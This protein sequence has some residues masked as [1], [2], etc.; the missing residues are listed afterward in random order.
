MRPSLQSIELSVDGYKI[1]G[2]RQCDDNLSNPTRALCLHGWL[3][4]ANSFIPVMPYLPALDLVAIDLP[5]HGYSDPL[6][7]GYDIGKLCFHISYVL[8]ALGWPSCHLIG[9][10]LGGCIAAYASVANPDAIDSLI[11]IE[12]S[13]PLSESAEKLPERLAR[14]LGDRLNSDRYESRTFKDKNEAIASRLKAAK[15]H[16]ASAKLIIDRQLK[17][18]EQGYVWRFDKQWR[19]ASAHYQTEEQVQ[20]V[21]SAVQCPALTVVADEGFLSG[22]AGTGPRLNCLAQGSIAT[23]PGHHHLHMDTPEPVAATINRFLQTEPAL[24]G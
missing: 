12:A 17:Q 6:P 11:M 8:K 3:D 14:A 18:T 20:A 5:G 15:M 22:R 4:N 1:A 21:L 13:G 24:G 9:H 16:D 10:S 23:L 7:G 19:F 2:I